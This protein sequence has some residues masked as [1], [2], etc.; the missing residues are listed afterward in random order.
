MRMHRR[1]DDP[2]E[3]AAGGEETVSLS[4]AASFLLDECRM[5]LPGIQALFGFQMIAVFN[6]RFA[7]DLS[8]VERLLHFASLSLVA[9]AIALIMTPAVYHRTEGVREV[10][11][12]FLR[13][14]TRLL[15]ASMAVLGLALCLD[16]YVVARLVLDSPWAAAPAAI[17]FATFTFFWIVLPRSNALKEML[18]RVPRATSRHHR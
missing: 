17:L 5:V 14:S 10:S 16:Y 11:G 13:N 1:K 18:D 7:D 4:D 6:Q 15:V 3:E 2:R 8:G 9:V 12:R